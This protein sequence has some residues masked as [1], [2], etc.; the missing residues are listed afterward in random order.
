MLMVLNEW[1]L[2]SL[3]AFCANDHNGG[4]KLPL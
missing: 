3:T 4:A 2:S 1:Q